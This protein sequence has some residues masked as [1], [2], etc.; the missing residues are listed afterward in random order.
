MRPPTNDNEPKEQA[1]NPE[2]EILEEEL[3]DESLN[4]KIKDLF[5]VD[6]KQLKADLK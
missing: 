6:L 3:D 2:D 1:D 4:K 5:Y